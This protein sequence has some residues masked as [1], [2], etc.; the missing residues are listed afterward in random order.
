MRQL[1]IKRRIRDICII[2]LIIFVLLTTIMNA[3]VLAAGA[4]DSDPGV[5]LNGGSTTG[6]NITSISDAV[7]AGV[8]SD[9]I[10]AKI[11]EATGKSDE[12]AN[13]IYTAAT[14]DTTKIQVKF[15]KQATGN[16]ILNSVSVKFTDDE[17]QSIMDG[18]YTPN[19]GTL[20]DPEYVQNQEKYGLEGENQGDVG[21][22]LFG[23][24]AW[25][26]Q[27]I[28]D[29]GNNMIQR[30]LTGDKSSVFY[31]TGWLGFDDS[32]VKEAVNRNPAIGDLPNVYIVRDYVK[33]LFGNYGVPEIRIT[34]AEI[35]AGN[36]A[37]L[38]ANFFATDED[39][40]EKLGGEEH[41][42]VVQLKPFIARWYVAL[43]NIA[44]VGLL[45]VLLYIGIRIIISS[46][47]GDKAKYKQMF[48]DWVVALCLIFFM[49]YIMAF[50]MTMSETVTDV[51]KDPANS[52]T[53]RNDKTS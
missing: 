32:D 40:S 49:H 24:I 2:C 45:S 21:G 9:E 50:T 42:I 34:P 48:I 31:S 1:N 37:A 18:T 16:V 29:V 33:S 5:D 15:T 7:A 23:P 41:S 27:G 26:L 8:S 28:G 39:V 20:Q 53:K 17:I 43:R 46:S 38:D 22:V 11:K 47:A 19:L 35:F 3:S 13:K 6:T 51:L 36:V 25:L 30:L 10:K 52:E 14:Q 44:I 4:M 12:E